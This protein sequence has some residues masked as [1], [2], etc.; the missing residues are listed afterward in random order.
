MSHLNKF[1]IALNKYKKATRAPF[2]DDDE[3]EVQEPVIEASVKEAMPRG[4]FKDIETLG[5]AIDGGFDDL[6][7]FLKNKNSDGLYDGREELEELNPS[8]LSILR[9]HLVKLYGI[10]KK[11]LPYPIC[12]SILEDVH[13]TV[14]TEAILK[15]DFNELL[16]EYFGT[17]Y[18]P[19]RLKTRYEP[20]FEEVI[21]NKIRAEVSVDNFFERV[22]TQDP[23][24]TTVA[25]AD[26]AIKLYGIQAVKNW[27]RNTAEEDIRSLQTANEFMYEILVE[28]FGGGLID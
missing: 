17:C 19:S 7:F 16:D 8:Q 25:S 13:I 5:Q 12:G 18:Q 15:L 11:N 9:S 14:P 3:V 28:R 26:D 4:P 24:A 1:K 10:F 23:I 22:I 2:K 21:A 27:W 6:L 20:D